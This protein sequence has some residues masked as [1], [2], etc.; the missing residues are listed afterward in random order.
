MLTRTNVNLLP[1]IIVKHQWQNDTRVAFT[2]Y[3]VYLKKRNKSKFLKKGHFWGWLMVIKVHPE[4]VLRR[5]EACKINSIS[6]HKTLPRQA[7]HKHT[8]SHTSTHTH[9]LYWI[10][11]MYRRLSLEPDSTAERKQ[12]NSPI[13]L[14]D[15]MHLETTSRLYLRLVCDLKRKISTSLMLQRFLL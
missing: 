5:D 4:V 15:F 7:A 11:P 3:Q 14:T 2:E 1:R 13:K 12:M 6:A 8:H 10:S 9:T